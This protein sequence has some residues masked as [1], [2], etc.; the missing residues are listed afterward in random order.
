LA[1]FV[2]PTNHQETSDLKSCMTALRSKSRRSFSL[3]DFERG[4]EGYLNAT[5]SSAYPEFVSGTGLSA[6]V[7][8]HLKGRRALTGAFYARR[9]VVEPNQINILPLRTWRALGA[10]YSAENSY[11]RVRSK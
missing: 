6:E 7:S 4:D 8:G 5:F 11:L 1:V 3:V 2:M 9:Q 10:A